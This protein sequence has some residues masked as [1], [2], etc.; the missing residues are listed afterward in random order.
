MTKRVTILQWLYDSVLVKEDKLLAEP[1]VVKPEDYKL[2]H[3]MWLTLGKP[4]HAIITEDNR[5]LLHAN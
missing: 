4:S 3:I 1:V 5:L 2:T